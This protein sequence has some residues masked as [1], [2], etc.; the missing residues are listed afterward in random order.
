MAAFIHVSDEAKHFRFDIAIGH[1]CCDRDSSRRKAWKGEGRRP[2]K[3]W[4]GMQ[5]RKLEL[6]EA[7]SLNKRQLGQKG[8]SPEGWT[9]VKLELSEVTK[10]K[11]AKHLEA[12][13][14]LDYSHTGWQRRSLNSGP[15]HKPAMEGLCGITACHYRNQGMQTRE[16][17][18]CQLLSINHQTVHHTPIAGGLA[19]S[20]SLWLPAAPCSSHC[21]DLTQAITDQ[22]VHLATERHYLAVPYQDTQ[23]YKKDKR[24]LPQKDLKAAPIRPVSDRSRERYRADL[25]ALTKRIIPRVSPAM[26]NAQCSHHTPSSAPTERESTKR[27][28]ATNSRIR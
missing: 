20:G 1:R 7:A 12:N 17:F 14:M 13:K 22:A 9:A 10:S 2:V 25:E 8:F 21:E 24:S 26:T 28:A 19:H 5:Q 18:S 4:A 27:R 6:F 11:Y 23:C 16:S 15:L 3:R